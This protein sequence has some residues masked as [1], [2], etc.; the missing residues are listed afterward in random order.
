MR[1]RKKINSINMQEEGDFHNVVF[2]CVIN[3]FFMVAGIFLNSVVIISFWRSR[4]LRKQLCYFMIFVLSCFDLA[5]VSITHPFLIAST[6]YY[7]LDVVSKIRENI[8]VS[9]SFALCDFSM[10]ALLTLNVERFL[11]L[12]R[13]YFHERSVT[14]T[15]LVC[16]QSFF[17]IISVGML[18]LSFVNTETLLAFHI[19]TFVSLS[20]V[21]CLLVYGNF[22]MFKIAKL[23][24]ADGRVTQS[25]ATST[26][27]IRRK[28]IVS[29]KNISTRFLVVG[30]FVLCTFPL[31][32]YSVVRFTS[33]APFFDR[34]VLLLNIWSNT[35][36]YINSTLNCLIFF[37]RNSILRREGMKI[38]NAFRAHDVN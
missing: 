37:W 38:I 26:K 14:K 7:F 33:G 13:P 16:L 34:Q 19:F 17:T 1:P 35:F 25:T 10:T 27:R 23:K 31:I 12:T 15:K 3:I 6:V 21:L 36:V 32:A 29:L 20:L 5:V 22:E 18:S 8:R 2:L 11:A 4:Q 28:L 24:S 9:I 30:C